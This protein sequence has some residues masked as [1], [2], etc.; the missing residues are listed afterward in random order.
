MTDQEKYT[1]KNFYAIDHENY[2]DRAIFLQ[3]A[4]EKNFS[5]FDAYA[6]DTYRKSFS[7][8]TYLSY[9]E[10]LAELLENEKQKL[11]INFEKEKDAEL[12]L[13]HQTFVQIAD[14]FINFV[15]T[16]NAIKRKPL[17]QLHDNMYS[18]ACEKSKN[19]FENNYST[20]DTILNSRNI[21]NFTDHYITHDKLFLKLHTFVTD[22]QNKKWNKAYGHIIKQLF[23]EQE[24][25]SDSL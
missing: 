3:K 5:M 13:S 23:E 12:I 16:E 21:L 15:K 2:A 9:S 22:K 8:L 6:R 11:S 20:I 1:W 24:K 17:L 19:L 14:E 25:Y 4:L 10:L 18:H 7:C